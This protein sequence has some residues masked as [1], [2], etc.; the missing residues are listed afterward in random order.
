MRQYGKL[1]PMND[2]KLTPADTM[3]IAQKLLPAHLK[4]KFTEVGSQD[5][6][7]AIPKVARFRVNVFHQR[8][9][10]SIVLRSVQFVIPGF[11]ELCLPEAIKEIAQNDRGLVLVTGVTGSGKSTTL[12]SMIEYINQTESLH[13]VTIEDPIEYLYQDKLC[14]INQQELG[15]DTP[16]FEDALKRVL[17][18]D[19]DVILIGEMRDK[20]TIISA[21]KAAETG[22]LVFSTLHTGD[23]TQ[24][25]DRILKYFPADEQDLIRMQLSLNLRGVISQR[26][27]KRHDQPGRVPAL[28]IMVG[29]PIVA[30]MIMQGKTNELRQ[31]IQN[32]E[33]GM[34]TFLQSLVEL[35]KSGKVS[36]DEAMRNTEHPLAL[37]RNLSGG[38]S[39][40]DRTSIIG[41]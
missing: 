35:V 14:I 16:S 39:D 4:D 12:A 41:F 34:Q 23:A 3:A 37:E 13:V 25:I 27:L 9:T 31:A 5:F 10:V 22:H 36:K 20:D 7:Y 26:L 19:P 11:E 29:T 33:K 32:R 38:Y 30:K 2:Q 6:S 40:G 18:Q 1:V 24:T 21:V 8:G 17:R 28:E 15:I